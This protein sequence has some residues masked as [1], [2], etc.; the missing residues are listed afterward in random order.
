M[1]TLPALLLASL[2]AAPASAAVRVWHLSDIEVYGAQSLTPAAVRAKYGVDIEH[3]LARWGIPTRG[4]Q[5]EAQEMERRLTAE[6]RRDGGYGWT[7]VTVVDAGRKGGTVDGLVV[8]DVVLK[9]QMKERY[10]FRP[11]PERDVKDVSGL[12]DDW[13]RYRE[14]ADAGGLAS[15]DE[16]QRAPCP[17][18]YCPDGRGGPDMG[19]LEAKFAEEVPDY[20]QLLLQ[21]LREDADGAKRARALYLLSYVKDVND[22]TAYVSYALTD[23]DARVRDAAVNILNDV[24]LN[25]KDVSLPVRDVARMLDYPT[26]DDRQHALALMLSLSD[27]P[28]ALSIIYGPAADQVIRLLRSKH[29]G[30]H[31][32]AYTLLTVLSEKKYGEHDYDAWD[33][34]LWQERQARIKR[35]RK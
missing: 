21:I 11:A 1:L 34:W 23:P 26:P 33:R 2:A 32:M 5:D 9:D 28:D 14:L 18:F 7:G 24:A 8:V 30:V 6:I 31:Q 35:G 3:M 12:L 19:K 27:D 16:L 15:G 25:R 29:P 4:A 10:P 13:A 22:L 17:A 20:K